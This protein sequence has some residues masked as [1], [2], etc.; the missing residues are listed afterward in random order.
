MPLG[1]DMTPEERAV[2]Y[3]IFPRFIYSIFYSKMNGNWGRAIFNEE[4]IR[5]RATFMGGISQTGE[6]VSRHDLKAVRK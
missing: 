4:N 6:E 5:L 1:N 3:S 2:R